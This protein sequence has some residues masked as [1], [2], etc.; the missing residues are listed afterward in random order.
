M[1]ET[2]RGWV[3]ASIAIVVA[4]TVVYVIYAL[5]DPK[6]P[7][8]ASTIGIIFGI[9]GFGFM[10]FAALLGARKRVPIWRLGRAQAWMRGHLWLGLLSLPMILFHGGFHFGGTLTSVLMWLLIITVV[11]GVF[12]AA[13]QHF[14]PRVMTTDVKLETSY[15]EIGNVRKRS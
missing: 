12:G 6:G 15:D 14:V 2:Q 5:T 10:I 3:V 11:S 9:I 7:R 4:S 8:G 13:L 1:D